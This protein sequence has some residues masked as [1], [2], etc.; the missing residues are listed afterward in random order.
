[1]IVSCGHTSP[2]DKVLLARADSLMEAHPDS[3]LTLLKH[4]TDSKH[5]SSS[6]HA[7]YALLMSQAFD[8]NDVDVQSDSLIRIAIAYYHGEKEFSRAGYAWF[9]LSH[10]E[11]NPGDAKERAAALLKAQS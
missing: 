1:L 3:A 8:K 10:V 2:Q 11:E 7:L 9:Y 6:D 4:I 5:L